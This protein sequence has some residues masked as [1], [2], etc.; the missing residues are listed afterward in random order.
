MTYSEKL[1][2]PRWQRLRL[3]VMQRDDFACCGCGSR[4]K[5]LNV[6]HT[7]Y[8]KRAM[9]WQYPTDSLVTL[10]EDCHREIE[11]L[12]PNLLKMI[13]TPHQALMMWRIAETAA[14]SSKN[15]DMLV[16]LCPVLD[17]L[18]HAA[19]CNQLGDHGKAVE[20]LGDAKNILDYLVSC[21]ERSIE[22]HQT[23]SLDW[24]IENAPEEP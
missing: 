12:L 10:C 7:H 24:L 18:E 17:F 13:R 21:I 8:L 9:P 20:Y 6:H 22:A 11:K 2:D 19:S 23:P 4:C 15:L 16:E 1:R 14:A 3:E 5:T